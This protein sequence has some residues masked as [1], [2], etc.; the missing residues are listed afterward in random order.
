MASQ[1]PR[2]RPAPY[3]CQGHEGRGAGLREKVGQVVG[4]ARGPLQKTNMRGEA[5][6]SEVIPNPILFLSWR[7][8]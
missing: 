7:S 3:N 8:H 2:V 4:W 1:P 5:C 6:Q